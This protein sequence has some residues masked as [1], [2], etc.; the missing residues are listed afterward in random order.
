LR[1]C[2]CCRSFL[3]ECEGGLAYGGLAKTWEEKNLITAK[4]VTKA[5]RVCRTNGTNFKLG[6]TTH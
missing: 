1:N 6:V 5:R 3:I 2:G 4:L